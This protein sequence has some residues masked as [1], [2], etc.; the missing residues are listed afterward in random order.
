VRRQLT[1]ERLAFI[2]RLQQIA[3]GLKD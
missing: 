2:R 1:P 3:S